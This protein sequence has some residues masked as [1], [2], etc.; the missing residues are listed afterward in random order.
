ME[1]SKADADP[2]FRKYKANVGT[3]LGAFMATI[4]EGDPQPRELAMR[5]GAM[6]SACAIY[7][8]RLLALMEYTHS[9]G[10]AG[11]HTEFKET[12]HRLLIGTVENAYRDAME[13]LEKSPELKGYDS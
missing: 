10:G 9:V 4:P 5:A 8:G 13:E 7:S 11:D 12:M 6:M 3:A 1:F 2:E